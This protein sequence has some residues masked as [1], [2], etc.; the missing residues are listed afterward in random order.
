VIA[1][2]RAP[3]A[4][5]RSE[6]R[7]VRVDGRSHAVVLRPRA[8]LAAE[9]RRGDLL[10]VN[11]AATLPAALAARTA[12]GATLELRLAGP[13]GDDGRGWAVA[14]GAGSWRIRTEDRPPPPPL[15]AGM[16]LAF[17]GGLAARVV[18]VSAAS[19]RLV[20]VAFDRGGEA[21]WSALYRAG[22][23]VQYSHLAGELA[24]WDVQ[25]PY[26][27]RPW[28]VEAPSAGLGFDLATLLELRR[29]GVGLARVTHA[30]G[31]SATGD[32]ALDR[33]LPLPERFEVPA[34]TVRAAARARRRGGRI[35]AVGTTVARALEGCAALHGGHLRPACGTTDLRLGPGVPR[36]VVDGLWTGL[37]APGT[38]HFDLLS[39]FASPALLLR[40]LAAAGAAGLH[41][42]EFG[43]GM[44]LLD[45]VP[46]KPAACARGVRVRREAAASSTSQRS[47]PGAGRTR[48][49]GG[50]ASQ[51]VPTAG[52]SVAAT[53]SA[54]SVPLTTKITRRAADSTGRV[55]VSRCG[56]SGGP[57]STAIT[58]R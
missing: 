5:P 2:A 3:R 47:R 32:P 6:G 16:A 15:D 19:P 45:Y 48:A 36:H 38:S 58:A 31:L 44:L 27:G 57:P 29:R 4:D 40:A 18:A 52:S 51:G 17:A 23:P 20:A 8:G 9:F 22:R 50:R 56:V 24:L 55:R 11:D 13:A 10:V 53:A 46:A 21:L 26:A 39:G 12:Q 35:I 37:H 1:P 41:G 34:A 54:L 14:F 33:L 7:F 42:E 28:A 25:T 30:A 43:D 49:A